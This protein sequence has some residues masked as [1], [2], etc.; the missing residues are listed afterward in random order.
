MPVG[1]PVLQAAT[2]RL[3]RRVAPVLLEPQ[4]QQEIMLA[5]FLFQ[6][7]RRVRALRVVAALAARAAAAAAASLV[8][9]V[10]LVLEMEEEVALVV[11]RAGM[12][13][14]EHMVLAVVLQFT[15]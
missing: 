1:T 7:A 15:S 12:A 2:E 14:R 8:Y 4:A 6:V 10:L 13:E 5:T 3:V 9:F 11:A